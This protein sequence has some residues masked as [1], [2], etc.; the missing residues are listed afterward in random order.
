MTGFKNMTLSK[1]IV[2][3]A[4]NNYF[5]GLQT[6][7]YSVQA[8][9]DIPILCFDIG[10]TEAQKQW[11]NNQPNL[12]IAPIPINPDI[13]LI[14]EKL[15]G[16]KPLGKKTKRQWPLWI[17]PWLIAASPYQRTFWLDCDI[18][19]LKNLNEL[20]AL[21]DAG[22]VFTQENLA[23]DKTPNKAELYELLPIKREFNP[24]IP[25]VNGG[26]SGWDLIRDKAVLDAYR[27]PILQACYQKEI[28]HAISWHDQGALIWAI[29]FCGLEHRVLTETHWNLCVRNTPAF[30]KKYSWHKEVI[31]ELARDVPHASL[32]HWNGC[33]VP[34]SE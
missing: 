23:P 22:P 33:A 26:V 19:V 20:F 1:G 27:Y 21:L 6:L 3:L 17:C 11:A 2:T 10:L 32:L 16:D 12:S 28:E 34:W 4:D 24:L 14:Q 5:S 25:T 9:A 31:I 8:L 30:N 18:V 29:Q 7:Y 15:Q 13:Q